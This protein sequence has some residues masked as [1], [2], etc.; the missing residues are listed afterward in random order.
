[1]KN[2]NHRKVFSSLNLPA[3][4]PLGASLIMWLLLDRLQP[5][6]WVWGAVTVLLLFLW[7]MWLYDVNTRTPVTLD[8]LLNKNYRE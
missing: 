7:A 8:E 2:K 6:G 4:M 3:R 1:M 5:P